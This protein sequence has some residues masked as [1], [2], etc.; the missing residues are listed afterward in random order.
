[1]PLSLKETQTLTRIGKFLYPFLPGQPH[2]FANQSISVMAVAK[3]VGLGDFWPGGSK[4]PA[5]NALLQNT[6]EYK[7]EKF[8]RLILGII[9]RGI[10]YS[11][12]KGLSITK[13]QIIFLNEMITEVG[14]KIPELWD[15]NFLDSLP[16]EKVEKPT[17][18][19]NTNFEQLKIIRDSYL[20]LEGHPQQLKGFDFERLLNELFSVFELKPRA[21]FRLQGEQIDGSLDFENQIYLVEAKYQTKPV[22]QEDLLVFRGKVEG[23]STWSQGLFISVSGFTTEGLAAFSHGRPTNLIAINGQDLFFILDGRI[24][25]NEVIR[26]KARRAA[27]TGEVMV[28]VQQ[29]LFES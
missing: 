15:Q 21:P 17:I 5:I 13:E 1:M 25:L 14:F 20:S 8:C 29:L 4:Q 2:P 27:E 28:S 6:L 24:T 18:V 19:K 9:Q 12:T 3:D 22:G 23:K 16:T 26:L 11:S 10:T 7:R